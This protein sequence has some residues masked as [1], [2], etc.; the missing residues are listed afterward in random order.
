M[1]MLPLLAFLVVVA[2]VATTAGQR[3]VAHGWLQRLL[4]GFGVVVLVF[5][6]FYLVT[7]LLM[8]RSSRQGH[9]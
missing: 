2:I 6:G 5:V 1:S 4:T 7:I 8:V 3:A 9:F